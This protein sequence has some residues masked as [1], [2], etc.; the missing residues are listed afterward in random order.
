MREAFVFKSHL[1]RFDFTSQTGAVKANMFEH[2]AAKR[3]VRVYEPPGWLAKS[4]EPRR[5]A[6][7]GCSFLWYLSFEQAKERYQLPG[8]PRRI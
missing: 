3:I 8:C 7:A 4:K 5:G 6:T 2:V 1:W